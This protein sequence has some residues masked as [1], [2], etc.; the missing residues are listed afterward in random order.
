MWRLPTST[1]ALLLFLLVGSVLVAGDTSNCSTIWKAIDDDDP[2]CI[3]YVWLKAMNQLDEIGAD[4]QTP[5]L[6]AAARGKVHSAKAL[7]E[8]GADHTIREKDTR[9]SVLDLAAKKGDHRMVNLLGNYKDI[10][11]KSIIQ[12]S[13]LLAKHSVDGYSPMH[14]ACLGNNGEYAKT[15][16]EFIDLGVSWD[17]K[18]R[19]GETCRDLTPS[20]IIKY[21][22][23]HAAAEESDADEYDEL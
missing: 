16:V 10:D 6:Y 19:D 11:G 5:L 7:L 18:T 13:L 20:Q 4:G 22:L 1:I 15:V 9:Y 2:K 17:Y 3:Q 12:D 14:R 8:L 23:L 21:A